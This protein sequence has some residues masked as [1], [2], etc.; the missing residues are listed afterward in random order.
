MTVHIKNNHTTFLKDHPLISKTDPDY[1]YTIKLKHLDDMNENE[2]ISI[3][4]DSMFKT[5]M[6]NSTR[7]TYSCKLL[8]YILDVP[9]E[10]LLKELTFGNNELD[11]KKVR[12]KGER[13]DFVAH[14]SDSS[15]DIEIN[16]SAKLH[17]LE[18]NIDYMNRLYSR[19]NKIGSKYNYKQSILINI[20]NFAYQGKDK[21]KY[22]HY[23]KD[24]ENEALT[25]KLIVIQI[26]IPN[27]IKKWYTSGVES[28]TEEE[29][30]LLVLVIPD[31]NIALDIGKD[32]EIMEEYINEAIE[33]TNDEDFKDFFSKEWDIKEAAYDD[34]KEDGYLDGKK[35]GILE[36][37]KEIVKKMLKENADINFIMK[38]TDLSKEEIE[39]L[40]A[41]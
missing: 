2:K 19:D 33:V 38:V 34:G 11:K 15:I 32:F 9:Y 22:I 23:L 40:S 4:S 1:K 25:D 28:L 6:T 5:M 16:C 8:S 18:R 21:V 14:V 24:E 35:E 27:L 17:L 7:K 12:D 26:Y 13:A 37:K 41:N 36:N 20:N 39:N 29:R 10:V 3:F 30:F 31:I